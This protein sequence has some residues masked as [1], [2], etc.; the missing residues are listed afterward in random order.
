MKKYYNIT[1]K[2]GM[3]EWIV[4][5]LNG[6]VLG[7][8]SWHGRWRQYCFYPETFCESWYS[9]DCLINIGQ[10]LK[11]INKAMQAERLANKE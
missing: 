9:W 11:D 7:Q 8:I 1:K 5:S 2:R 4:T 10:D 6:D 3:K